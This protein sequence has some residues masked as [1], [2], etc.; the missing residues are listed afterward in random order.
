MTQLVLDLPLRRY[1][2]TVPL[3]PEA[4]AEAVLQAKE[5]DAAVLALFDAH[6]G[7]MPPSE[8][9]QLGQAHGRRWLLTSVRRSINTLTRAQVLVKL[10]D[11]VPGLYGR[12]EHLWRRA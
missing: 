8:V 10:A 6:P 3:S 5:Q 7:P 2:P 9:W 11:T 12:P 1:F 4:L